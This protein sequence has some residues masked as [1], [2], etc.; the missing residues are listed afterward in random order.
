[1]AVVDVTVEPG[2][3][4][5]RVDGCSRCL[6]PRG[7]GLR[8]RTDPRPAPGAPLP[9]GGAACTGE[10][11][12]SPLVSAAFRAPVVTAPETTREAAPTR[13]EHRHG[14]TELGDAA[15]ERQG[16]EPGQGPGHGAEPGDGDVEK[17]AHDPRVELRAR[18][19]RRARLGPPWGSSPSCSYGPSS[20][21]RSSRRRPR[22][23]RRARS[24]RP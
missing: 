2:P 24:R 13:L 22:S 8:S 14:L 7:V 11:R 19:R 10:A 15:H 4:P 3:I 20:W 1:M 12:P 5:W 9:T 23:D 18:H 17:G 6:H 16:A 21:C